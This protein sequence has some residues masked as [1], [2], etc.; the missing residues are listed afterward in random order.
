[1]K[2]INRKELKKEARKTVKI[3]YLRNVIVAFIASILLF[4]GITYNS[5]NILNEGLKDQKVQQIFANNEK[6]SNDQIIK[7][8]LEQDTAIKV[9]EKMKGKYTKGILSTVFNE[10]T[11]SGS[12]FFGIGNAINIM[13]F[14]EKISVGVLIIVSNIAVAAFTIIC[15]NTIDVGKNRYFLEKRR[16]NNTK[17][18]QILYT[19][20]VRKNRHIAYI[21]FVKN[22][23]QILWDL[24][25][26]GGFIKNYEYKLIPFILAENPEISLKDAFKLSKEMSYGYKWQLFKLDVSLIGWKILDGITLNISKIFYSD[27]YKE[28]IYAEAYMFIRNEKLNESNKEILNDFDLDIPEKVD[29]EY[30]EIII[31]KEKYRFISKLDYNKNYTF[32]TYI[33]LFFT[34]SICGWIW[35]VILML[36]SEGQL[37]NRGALH[38]PWLPIYGS[39]G[40]LI[41]F[42]LKRFRNNPKKLFI[43]SFISCGIVEYGTSLYLDVFKHVSYWD[44]TGMFLNINGRVCLEGLLFFAIGGL[45]FTYLLA[46][47]LDEL[48]K[49][50]KPNIKKFMCI[51][52]V[53]LFTIDVAYSSV[54]PN[55]GEGISEDLSVKIIK[56]IA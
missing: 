40:V 20:K 15:I 47:L 8:I 22:V 55:K 45:G 50:I 11:K 2:D 36:V 35:E 12:L 34:F 19:Y 18:Q 32:S 26:V 37:V 43:A 42:L 6:K 39:G 27:I 28:C 51:I 5:K 44:Y 13:V 33:L 23:R 49:K 7:E 10:I 41:L 14:Q 48:Y 56:T 1:M 17:I 24:T 25:I 54:Y 38:G 52:L 53:V 9:D 21:L 3:H 30:P 31:K 4:G 16:Y 46:P 29:R